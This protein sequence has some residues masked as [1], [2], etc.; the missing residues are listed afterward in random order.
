V[1]RE[2]AWV[3]IWQ[4]VRGLNPLWA[5]W[6]LFSNVR[7]AVALIVFVAGVSLLGVLLPQIPTSVRGDPVSEA[8]WLS[9]QRDTFG[10]FTDWMYRV[11]IF[12]IFH[13]YWFAVV[14]GLLVISTAVYIL[15]RFPAIWWAITRPRKRVPDV[16]FKTAP[17]RAAWTAMDADA[18]ETALR[19]R[20]YAVERFPEGGTTYFFADRFR[21]AEM[22]TILTHAAVVLFV[23]AAVV[24]RVSG[25]STDLFIAEGASAPVFAQVARADQMQAR[26]L[27]AVGTFDARGQPLDYRS[28]LEIAQGGQVVK[29]C[30]TT[31]NSPCTYG[32]YRF[33]QAA[34]F[35][36]GA[37]MQVRDL[38]TGNVVY[39]E[40]LALAGTM[41]A[42]RFV[43]RDAN[44][45]VLFD[46]TVVLTEYV[47][48]AYGRLITLPS[49][50]RLLWVGIRQQGD[51]WRLLVLEPSADP[52][53][54]QVSLAEG[55]S[56]RAGGLAF[57]FTRLA[58]IPA[59]FETDLPLP[60]SATTEGGAG[61][62]LVQMSNAVYGSGDASAGT[63]L[64]V[65]Q[66]QGP[67]TLALVGLMPQPLSLKPGEKGIVDDFEYTFLGQRDFAG[68]E[69][70]K[71]RSDS[72]IWVATGLL[73]AGLFLTFWV[74]RRRL[75]ARITPTEAQLASRGGHAA[76]FRREARQLARA[77][78]ARLAEDDKELVEDV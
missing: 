74:P 15:G 39:R 8:Q 27:D 62:V 30:V 4:S 19:R 20:W 33:H 78:G 26:V 77:T 43:V 64:D 10:P 61:T 50:G 3:G 6:W 28:D 1:A 60:L 23:V 57:Q 42:P 36:F 44:G 68:I 7:W 34:Y 9:L 41:P 47:G 14:L 48:D 63:T 49:S 52:D 69:V 65:P 32:G 13:A 5:V 56:G 12:D 66:D 40:T 58:R 17:Q 76:G 2:E 72:L 18:F 59:S 29:R 38:A 53:A 31:V 73:L 37:E 16:Y 51:D 70:R 54:V 46:E 22:G 21:W 55:A 71:D 25:F 35:G 45:Q 24:S 67:P 75:W 11:G